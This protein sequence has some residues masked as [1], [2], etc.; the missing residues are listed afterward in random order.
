MTD[1]PITREAVELTTHKLGVHALMI[2]A[3]HMTHPI[4]DALDEVANL[5]RALRAELDRAEARVAELEASVTA[6]QI[7]AAAAALADRIFV[8]TENRWLPSMRQADELARVAL[9]ATRR[10]DKG[11]G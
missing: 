10:T 4:A 5:V 3:N 6:A 11:D 2:R 9:R 1:T 8:Q 7:E